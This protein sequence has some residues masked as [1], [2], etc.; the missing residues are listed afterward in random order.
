MS[1]VLGSELTPGINQTGLPETIA[2]VISQMPE[3]LQGMFWAHVVIV[4]GL[5]KVEA[6]G[7]R[8]LVAPSS[9]SNPSR[10]RDLRALCPTDY[11]IG[12]YEVFE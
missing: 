4:G 2:Y 9:S 10:E 8:L 1:W 5:G 12:I 11:D 7:E 6:L 3:E